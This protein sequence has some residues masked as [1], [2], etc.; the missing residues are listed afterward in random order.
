MSGKTARK[1]RQEN[2]GRM[3]N[4]KMNDLEMD[5]IDRLI[6]NDPTATPV[7]VNRSP[8]MAAEDAVK[9]G[10][11]P[12]IGADIGAIFEFEGRCH[13]PNLLI[14]VRRIS[15][16][17]VAVGKAFSPEGESMTVGFEF[18][19]FYQLPAS[20]SANTAFEKMN[21]TVFF[22]LTNAKTEFV[23]EV[24]PFYAGMFDHQLKTY[25]DSQQTKTAA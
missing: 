4:F 21:K 13:G 10:L 11:S 6:G 22:V 15:E 20:S 5:E 2:K 9:I 23:E 25:L 3:G 19:G 12:E 1:K 14:A 8:L 16:D 7:I 24:A 17:T 18:H